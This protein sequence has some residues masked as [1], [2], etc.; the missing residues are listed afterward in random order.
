MNS[1]RKQRGMTAIGRLFTLA[2][3]AFVLVILA[4]MVPAYAE[5]FSMSAV[6]GSLE[7][8]PKLGSMS[9]SGIKGII[10]KKASVNLIDSIR[11]EDI[12]ISVSNNKRIIELDYEIRRN[13]LGNHDIVVSFHDSVEVPVR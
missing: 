4:R 7:K 13:L 10:I 3:L 2:L 11:E 9:D 8:V 12:S 5:Y 1:I 6:M